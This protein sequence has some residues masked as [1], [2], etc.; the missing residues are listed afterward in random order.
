MYVHVFVKDLHVQAALRCSVHFTNMSGPY[1]PL[2]LASLSPPRVNVNQE[3]Y[4]AAN[5]LAMEIFLLNL[6]ITP[7][8][9]WSSAASKYIYWLPWSSFL[10]SWHGWPLSHCGF[11][12]VAG[13]LDYIRGVLILDLAG[14]A[15][16]SQ[17]PIRAFGNSAVL[18]SGRPSSPHSTWSTRRTCGRKLH[19]VQ[20]S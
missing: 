9:R 10:S 19:A 2:P 11:G 4:L 5:M 1:W 7:K 8:G 3:G 14:L 12:A 16:S 20:F 18:P 15:N 17:I 6:C 13:A